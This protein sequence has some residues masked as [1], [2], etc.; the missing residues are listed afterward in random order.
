MWQGPTNGE[1]CGMEFVT[2]VMH[3]P[4]SCVFLYDFQWTFIKCMA[5]VASQTCSEEEWHVLC[6]LDFLRCVC[7]CLT[8]FRTWCWHLVHSECKTMLHFL[9][10]V[11][12]SQMLYN[13]MCLLLYIQ[14]FKTWIYIDFSIEWN[15]I[16]CSNKIYYLTTSSSLGINYGYSKRLQ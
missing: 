11:G 13:F 14:C 2:F 9:R 15:L 12:P 10:F 5:C 3:P 6:F 1:N 7:I 8:T 4:L 16:Y